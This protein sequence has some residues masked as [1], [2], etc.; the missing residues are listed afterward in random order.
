MK[1][2]QGCCGSLSRMG[3]CKVGSGNCPRG[4]RGRADLVGG[5]LGFECELQLLSELE[6]FGNRGSWEVLPFA[7]F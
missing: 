5:T 2:R 6:H 7:L 4:T 3:F 1:G